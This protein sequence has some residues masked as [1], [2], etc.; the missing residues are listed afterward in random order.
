MIALGDGSAVQSANVTN[1]LMEYW[2]TYWDI[3]KAH[4]YCVPV[5]IDREPFQKPEK[6]QQASINFCGC[7]STLT[8]SASFMP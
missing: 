6:L 4:K 8:S 7:G 2:S 1:V 5:Y 3:G